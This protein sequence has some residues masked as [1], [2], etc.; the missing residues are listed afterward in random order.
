MRLPPPLR[1]PERVLLG[2]GPSPVPRSVLTA[3]SHPTIGHLDPEFHKL[4]DECRGMLREVFGT[5]NSCTLP[6]SGTGSAGMEA[7]LVNLLRPGCRILVGLNGVFGTRLADVARRSGADVTAVPQPWGRTL[8][9]EALARAAAGKRYDLVCCVHAETSTGVLQPL[10]PLRELADQLGALLLVDTVTSLAGVPVELDRVGVDVT[11]AATQKC[12]SCP[13]GLSPISLSDRALKQVASQAKKAQSWYFDLNLLG[14][15][16]GGERT[17]HH[18]APIH[19][20]YGLHEALRLVLLE[21][22]EARFARH[23]AASRALG[24]GLEALGLRLPV[25]ESERLPPLTLVEA[26]EGVNEARVRAE[27][28]AQHSLE[29]GAGLGE[30]AGKAWR[31]GLM[32]EGASRANVLGCLGALQQALRRQGHRASGCPVEAAKQALVAE[33]PPVP[34]DSLVDPGALPTATIATPELND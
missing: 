18:T 7:C 10:A 8:D 23:A 12:L 30:F 34:P 1:P 11:Y 26:P 2:P 27:L 21:G 16:F 17:Y 9:T 32:G 22:L 5:T 6:I 3:L 15:Y 20:V 33:R 13:P 31:I 14:R 28:L 24:A 25:P 4:L 29:I 19:S